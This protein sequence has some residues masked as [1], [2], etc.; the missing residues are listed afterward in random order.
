[1]PAL[2]ESDLKDIQ[3]AVEQEFP[4]DDAL[5]QVHIA[6]K[7][8]AKEAEIEGLSIIEYVKSLKKSGIT[9]N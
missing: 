8:L 4:E 5:Q 3:K 1:M 9:S 6:R 7:I 2:N